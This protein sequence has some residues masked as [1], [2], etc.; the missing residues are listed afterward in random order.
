MKKK[1]NPTNNRENS[2]VSILTTLKP[3]G[4]TGFEGL[5]RELL[6]R[7]TSELFRLARAGSQ[8]GK[9]VTSDSP[10]GITL[11]VEMKRYKQGSSIS[12][13][14]LLGE[15][16]E[17][18]QAL[19][20]LDLWVLATTT[21]I[22]DKEMQGIKNFSESM[23]IESLILDSRIDGC[24]Y[25]EV[26]CARFPDII[27]DFCSKNSQDIKMEDL[28]ISISSIQQNVNYD[29]FVDQLCEILDAAVFGFKNARKRS[30]QWF[31]GHIDNQVKSMAGFHQD[32]GLHDK[33]RRLPII[34]SNL[35][36]QFN[37][38]YKNRKSEFDHVVL[39]GEEGTGKTWA[40]MAWLASSFDDNTGPI[41]LPVTSAQLS[42]TTDLHELIIDILIKRC[43]KTE[44]F[45]KKRLEGW[46]KHHETD[47]P[48]FLLYLDGL[49]EKPNFL[50]RHLIL[51]SNSD[52]W[53]KHV[54]IFMSSRNDFFQSNL[55]FNTLSIKVIE[56]T[57]YDANELRQE[58]A[59]VGIQN[60]ISIPEELLILI[61]KPRYCDLALRHFQPLL[62]SGD[63]TIERLIYQDYKERTAKN[64]S[65][66]ITDEDF[67]QILCNLANKYI[68][69]L[70]SFGKADIVKT[71]PRIDNTNAIL[72]EIID[73]GLLER[74]GLQS[75]PYRVEKQKLV[76]GL[77]MLL[78][79]Y[80]ISEPVKT[81]D[82]YT[83]AIEIWLEPHPDMELKV[84]IVGAAV[85]FSIMNIDYHTN[86][87]QA[88]LRIWIGS[89][90]MTDLQERAI[91]AYL[92]DSINDI[93][94]VADFFWSNLQD[95]GLAQERLAMAFLKHRDDLKVKPVLID[96]CKR[97]MSYININGHPFD[98][99]LKEANTIELRQKLF[100][101]LGREVTTGDK[102]EFQGR[103]F[104]ITEDDNMLRMARFAMLII[105]A[106]D[107]IS[108][109]ESF[110]QWAIS[111]RLMGRH[112]E[113]EEASWILRLTE[114]D[115][116]HEF[117]LNL[118]Q[119]AMSDNET[120]KEAAHLL[121]NCIGNRS[122]N[123]L[124]E[125]YLHDLYPASEFQIEYEKDPYASIFALS[126]REDYKPCMA[127]D[128]L[129]LWH[130]VMK[131]D[132]YLA[133]P[134]I[135]APESFIIRLCEETQSLPVEEYRA[136]LDHTHDDHIID[137]FMPVLARFTFQKLGE[138]IRRA[139][140]TLDKRNEEGVNQLLIF[141][142]KM[143][144]VLHEPELEIL[145]NILGTY[146]SKA[147]IW[148]KHADGGYT[149]RKVYAVSRGTLARIMHL[150]VDEIAEFILN[151]PD[152]VLDLES[153]ETWFQPLPEK[154]TCDYLERL[155]T[156]SSPISQYRIL[157]L[158]CD[159]KPILSNDHRQKLIEWMESNNTTLKYC[160]IKFVWSS[161]DRYLIDHIIQKDS[162]LLKPETSRIDAWIANI[163][164]RY[165]ND[166]SLHTLIKYLPLKWISK[167]IYN[168]SCR[169]DD[170]QLFANLLDSV[171]QHV[172][173]QEN[174]DDNTFT[175]PQVESYQKTGATFVYYKEPSYNRAIRIISPFLSWRS[176]KQEEKIEIHKHLFHESPEDFTSRQQAFQRQIEALMQKDGTQ[177]RYCQ[178]STD[179]LVC[180]YRD[181]PQMVE[182]W[183]NKVLEGSSK[184][185]LL[186]RC[187]GFYQSLCSA[188]VK[189]EHPL[190]FI[191]WKKI[192]E[193]PHRVNFNNKHIGTDWMTYLP[194]SA[195]HF[196]DARNAAV[197]MIENS[198]SDIE[199]LELANAACAY[200]QQSWIMEITHDLIGKPQLWIRAKGLMLISL[201]DIEFGIDSFVKSSDLDGTWV[202]KLLPQIKY[203]HYRNQWAR[204]WYNRFLI[205]SDND[206]AF[207]C[208]QLF[209]KSVDRR[210]FLWMDEIDKRVQEDVRI[211]ENRIKFRLTNNDQIE[212]AIKDN[213]KELND[214]FLT[215]KYDRGQILPFI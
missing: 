1:L 29:R 199:L 154:I 68:T 10:S 136:S 88:L 133:D 56:T 205:V 67:N 51:E 126:S 98:R 9:D 83:N 27:K 208:F 14:E 207:A 157:W 194:F 145:D 84:S 209:L 17:V 146:Y 149:D 37:S 21:E 50:W 186:F 183:I 189:I 134:D 58:L 95:N 215:L 20:D 77:G 143:G 40:C 212:S 76:Y 124:L 8:T 78:A 161:G 26:F 214:H 115:I 33:D 54:A 120:L 181:N 127:R 184:N 179:V 74:T 210:C 135:V 72:Q 53:H 191:L 86:A 46:L 165:V 151:R 164:C 23:G 144:I 110:L 119:M 148:P 158:L 200:R 182:K 155:L 52:Y 125:R 197:E 163:Y 12:R 24:G 22:G 132:K 170:V 147:C 97:W 89:R 55:D 213:E 99:S 75:T 113:F 44:T 57:G 192:R 19:P 48:L 6:E 66:P 16:A 152:K 18:I 168:N 167:V 102:V 79:D 104:F 87:R 176:N 70:R 91:S 187:N 13:R 62:I 25:F 166:L 195:I 85:F 211:N 3:I 69:G 94:E 7:W 28:E 59:L 129:K 116:W 60:S 96:A 32:I 30:C 42:G 130:I 103:H 188:L 150:N 36:E 172:S 106:G 171:W 173:Q 11:A 159:S 2:L 109:I 180:V 63:L 174:K 169:P 100:R 82:E 131:L 198:Y 153:L 112:S 139:V 5:I 65:Q 108:F 39:L 196:L 137:T 101:R 71:L 162:E 105:S 80:L 160:T 123:E 190:S 31:Q 90:N 138:I 38:W 175:S 49:N 47:E 117:E 111:R 15:L 140:H 107:R 64:L 142:P 193:N 121:S 206:E 43:G 35:N 61:R 204:H 118:T 178:L 141:L 177:L 34:R 156:E 4:L 185:D 203:Y 73:G 201:A 122:A 41:L 81:I 45:W 128:D 93:V 92:P 114:E 202:E